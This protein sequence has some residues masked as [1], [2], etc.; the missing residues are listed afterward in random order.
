MADHV[1]IVDMLLRCGA[2]ISIKNSNGKS[3]FDIVQK[4]SKCDKLLSKWKR[5]SEQNWVPNNDVKNIYNKDMIKGNNYECWLKYKRHKFQNYSL[6]LFYYF[7]LFA[8]LSFT[9]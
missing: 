6:I 5:E 3:I 8:S 1:D 7:V 9:T 4:F 2:D